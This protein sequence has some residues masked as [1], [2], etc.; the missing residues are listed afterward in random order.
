M[1][2]NKFTEKAQE[3]IFAAQRAA[4]DASASEI[5]LEHLVLALL[6]Q[7]GGII[8]DLIR[9]LGASPDQLRAALRDLVQ[10]QPKVYGAAQPA[11]SQ[12][13]ARA[14]QSAQKEA[15]RLKDDYVSTEHLFLGAIEAGGAPAPPPPRAPGTPR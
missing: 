11:L 1:D 9:A 7:D 4:Q 6:E 5:G 2:L 10:K 3:A 12:R 8:P 15:E 13:L 14:I